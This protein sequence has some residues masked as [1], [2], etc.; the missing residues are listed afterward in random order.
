VP[1][2]TSKPQVPLEPHLTDV[3]SVA[4]VIPTYNRGM[5]VLSVLGRIHECRPMPAEIWIH[6]D[7]ADGMLEHELRRRFPAVRVLTSP[8]QLGP[9][10]GRHRCLLACRAPYAVS[11]DDD[12]YPVDTDFFSTVERLYSRHPEAAI[13]GTSI[14]H[15]HEPAKMRTENVVLMPSYMGCGH[16]IRLAAY[17]KTR[18]YLSRPQAYGM[19]ESDLSLQLF[20]AGWSIYEAGELRV[21][22]DTDLKHHQSPEVT[23]GAIANVGL[24]AF[25]NYPIRG[26]GRGLLQLANKVAYCIRKGR[27]RGILSG[28]LRIPVD[29]YRNRQHRQPIAW[30]TVKKFLEFRK[31]G[32]AWHRSGEYSW[33]DCDS[34]SKSRP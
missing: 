10:G 24:Y 7:S 34:A 25:L 19:E 2:V 12:S 32:L 9:G 28:I 1:A 17:Q 21:F 13:F 23:A 18:G 4:V 20:A 27:I 14:W 15:R 26:W 3:V 16:A 33:S 6:V 5:A 30:K 11:F 29:C 22:H 8:V 31:T